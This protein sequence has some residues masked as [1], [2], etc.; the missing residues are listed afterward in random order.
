[1]DLGIVT[2]AAIIVIAYF[3]GEIV[4]RTPLNDKWIPVCC[5]AAGAI[6]GILAYVIK[7]P[8]MLEVAHDPI[9]AVAVG[10]ASGFAATG[11]NQVYKQLSRK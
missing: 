2:I 11:V 1:M 3:V 7:M 4:K 10:I 6:L 8:E 5:G 9:T